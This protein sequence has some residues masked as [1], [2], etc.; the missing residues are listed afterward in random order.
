MQK[1]RQAKLANKLLQLSLVGS[2]PRMQDSTVALWKHVCGLLNPTMQF[3]QQAKVEGSNIF[4]W[5]DIICGLWAELQKATQI[6]YK[7]D[8]YLHVQC[9]TK[10]I[11]CPDTITMFVYLL[12]LALAKESVILTICG[13]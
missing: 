9:N 13:I 3:P 10:H 6:H 12:S 8:A 4:F 1:L 7:A 2:S 5:L 11:Y